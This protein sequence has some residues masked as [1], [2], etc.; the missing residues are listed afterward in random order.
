MQICICGES[1]LW[2]HLSS[3]QVQDIR[4]SIYNYLKANSRSFIFVNLFLFGL[5]LKPTVTLD[6]FTW[7]IVFCCYIWTWTWNVKNALHTQGCILKYSK[8]FLLLVLLTSI[9]QL[10]EFFYYYYEQMPQA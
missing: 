4:N 9:H 5:K 8:L 3:R 1:K 10:T 7:F 6:L 2:Q